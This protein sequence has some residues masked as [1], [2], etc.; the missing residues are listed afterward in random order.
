VHSFVFSIYHITQCHI[1]C[2]DFGQGWFAG[3]HYAL[4]VPSYHISAL[5][6]HFLERIEQ[7]HHPQVLK[8]IMLSKPFYYTLNIMI[9]Y[10]GSNTSKA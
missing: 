6:F 1:L 7:K 9:N 5:L 2:K 3:P 8:I 10:W 4:Q